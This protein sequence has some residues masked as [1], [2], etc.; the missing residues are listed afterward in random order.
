MP[1]EKPTLFLSL[2]PRFAELLLSGR[3]TVELR[4]IRPAVAEGTPVLLYAS[5][6]RMTL[7]G[8]AR[9]ATV[10]VGT[11]EEIW[12]KHGSKTGISKSEYDDY[13]VGLDDAVAIKLVYIRR[14][15]KPRPLQ[16]LRDSLAGFQPPQSY[17]YLD[18]AQVAALT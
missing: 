4:R 16:D 14:L 2:R 12:R 18:S 17:R 10:E 15:D 6:P 5:S 3:K 8:R 11:T 9:V 7:V 13:F 1:T